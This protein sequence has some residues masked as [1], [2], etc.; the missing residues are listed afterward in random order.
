VTREQRLVFGEVAELYERARPSYPAELIDDVLELAGAG[1]VSEAVDVG[2]GTGKASV[3]LAER[4]VRG[5][6]VEPDPAM[7]AIARRNLAGHTGW[8]VVLS[9]FEEWAGPEAAFDLVT[10]A[11]SWHWVGLDARMRRAHFV[12]RSGGWLALWWN[13][14]IGEDEPLRE[15]LDEVYR[16][17]AP[18]LVDRW[19]GDREKALEID[20]IPLDAPFGPPVVRSYDWRATYSTEQYVELLQTHSGHRLLPARQ[21]EALLDGVAAVIDEAGGAK[22]VPYDCRLWAAPRV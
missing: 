18:T 2:C 3:L 21:L 12:L 14:L 11:Q 13:V 20:D 17:L 22:E 19:L 4:G 1:S 10:A 6:G 15:P 7:A 16:R 9:G 8:E 5:V